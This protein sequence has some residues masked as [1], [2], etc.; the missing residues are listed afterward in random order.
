MALARLY[1]SFEV[2][3]GFGRFP[4][5]L[6]TR[7]YSPL[8]M[9]FRDVLPHVIE[10]VLQAS[11]TRESRFSNIFLTVDIY[12][13]LTIPIPSITYENDLY[14]TN[15]KMYTCRTISIQIISIGGD[16]YHRRRID[17]IILQP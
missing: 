5:A 9:Y 4:A 14:C 8:R 16:M 11:D 1:M 3:L 13:N 10:S 12:T 17:P 7:E 2:P 15:L 6:G